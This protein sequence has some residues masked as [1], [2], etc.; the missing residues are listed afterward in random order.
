MRPARP[1]P[2]IQALE[3]LAADERVKRAEEALRDAS[4]ELRWHEA[5]RRRW[6]EARAEAA[7]RGAVASAAVEGAVLPAAILRDAVAERAL[8][9]ASTGDSSLDAAAGLWRAGV[10]LTEWMPDLRGEGRPT[11]PSPRTLLTALHRDVAGP[12]AA[13]GRIPLDA[14]AIPRAA[15]RS[16]I[17]GGPGTAPDGEVLRS[18]IEAL[19]ELIDAPGAPA[20]VRAAIAHGEMVTARPFTAAN[21]AVGR[22]LVR[23]LITRDGLEPTGVAVTDQYAARVP[24][25]YADAASA[26][27]SG[28][29]DGVVAWIVWQAEAILVGIEEAQSIC[30][31]IQA[32]TTRPPTHTDR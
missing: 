10:R 14:V 25:A 15:G 26:Y 19:L 6:R 28:E 12:L 3:A 27:A 16:P 22:L 23:H 13:T 18:R 29:P 17:E 7:V 1:S 2:I 11:Q 30:R 9:E 21:A 24:V 8:T 5:L 20:L 32:G 31:S 4:A